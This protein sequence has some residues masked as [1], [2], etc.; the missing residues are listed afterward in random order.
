[1]AKIKSSGLPNNMGIYR[2]NQNASLMIH[3][4]AVLNL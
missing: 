3:I 1:M 2:I 4:L